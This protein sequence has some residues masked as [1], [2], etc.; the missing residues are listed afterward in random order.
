MDEKV[1]LESAL[2]SSFEAVGIAQDMQVHPNLRQG[3]DVRTG[4][5]EVAYSINPGVST[6]GASLVDGATGEKIAT[7]RESVDG[8]TVYDMGGGETFASTTNVLGDSAIKE[9]GGDIIGFV[10][11][12]SLGGMQL[13][14]NAHR[15][16]MQMNQSGNEIYT[17]NP[18]PTTPDLSTSI[19]GNSFESTGSVYDAVDG[20]DS[21][22]SASDALDVIDSLGVLGDL[23]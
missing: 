23:F 5:G 8:R 20:L 10:N 6:E 13:Q 21:L 16:I 22:D 18:A 4:N 11:S 1:L 12:N 14:D 7:I 15:S 19:A 17:Q 3:L 2:F 9:T